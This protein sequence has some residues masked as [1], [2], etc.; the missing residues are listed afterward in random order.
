[1]LD[2]I[3]FVIVTETLETM[4]VWCVRIEG[5]QLLLLCARNIWKMREKRLP[6]RGN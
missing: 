4:A 2:N 1:M 6:I 5:Q 3:L